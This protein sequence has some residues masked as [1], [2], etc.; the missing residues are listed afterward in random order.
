MLRGIPK[1]IWIEQKSRNRE[2]DKID[3]YVMLNADG[4]LLAGVDCPQQGEITYTCDVY[5][6]YEQRRDYLDI[7]HA[8]RFCEA[9]AIK[10]LKKEEVKNRKR[11]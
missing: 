4:R 10:A 6:G 5:L 8:K 11:R 1:Y 3:S 9:Q 2:G 7:N